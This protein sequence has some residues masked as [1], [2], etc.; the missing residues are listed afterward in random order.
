MASST[1]DLGPGSLSFVRATAGQ[2]F[3]N[4]VDFSIS[5]TGYTFSAEIVSAVTG[6][7]IVPITVTATNLAAGQV[8][9]SLTGAQTTA[10]AR[11]SYLWRLRWTS[12]TG[13][14]RTVLEGIFEVE[15]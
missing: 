5:L 8:T 10:I 4:L 9:L 12:P 14:V 7:Q 3:S 2:P 6:S 13:E 15:G 1:V 11:G